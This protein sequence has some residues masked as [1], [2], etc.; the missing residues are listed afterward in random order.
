MHREGVEPS[1]GSLEGSCS[2]SIELPVRFTCEHR[3]R[4]RR[5]TIS[6]TMHPV[7]LEPTFH[8]LRGGGSAIELRVHFH[9]LRPFFLS[10]HRE[11]LEPSTLGFVNRSSDPIELPVRVT[12]L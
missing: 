6:F 9:H 2:E 1:T 10:M 3:F 5:M 12:N 4:L 8:R 11:G 7:G